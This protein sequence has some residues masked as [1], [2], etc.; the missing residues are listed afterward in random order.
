M[1]CTACVHELFYFFFSSRRRHTRCALVTGVQTCALPISS[2][3]HRHSATSARNTSSAEPFSDLNAER[4]VAHCRLISA[5]S[6]C[7]RNTRSGARPSKL[8]RPRTAPP[9]P[10]SSRKSARKSVVKGKSGSSSVDLGGGRII[11]KKTKV[12][13]KIKYEHDN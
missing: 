1:F 2:T 8:Y 9:S 10:D 5:I 13:Y 7:P 6:P 12:Q 3:S 11:K 4:S